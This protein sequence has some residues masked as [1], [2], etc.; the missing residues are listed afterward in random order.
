MRLAGK[1]ML[2]LPATDAYMFATYGMQN[3]D[4]MCRA[5]AKDS[6]LA[7]ECGIY[8]N[9]VV[10]NS[11]GV[12]HA[13]MTRFEK[14]SGGGCAPIKDGIKVSFADLYAEEAL[15]DKFFRNT[16]KT[17]FR[18]KIYISV[19]DDARKRANAFCKSWKGEEYK[20]IKGSQIV[21][22]RGDVLELG[23]CVVPTKQVVWEFLLGQTVTKMIARGAKIG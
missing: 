23:R 7:A 11:S 2:F 14:G 1:R 16:F 3:D 20:T 9:Y 4:T 18:G 17:Y 6:D 10:I 13:E 19:D 5:K 15:N 8:E 21:N 22:E 12:P